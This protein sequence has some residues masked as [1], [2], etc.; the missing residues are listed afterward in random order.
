MEKDKNTNKKYK[1]LTLAQKKELCEKKRDQK[2]NNAQLAAHYKISIST[3]YDITKKSEHWLSIDINP[4]NIN[5]FREKSSNYPQLEEVMIIWVDQQISRNLTI[6]G[7]IIQQKAKECANLLDINNF[8]ASAGWLANF[9]SRNNLHAFKISGEAGSAPID[10]LPQM[11][12]ELQEVLQGY[13]LKDIW[14][15]DETALFW[16]LEPCKTIAH[17][18]VLG[19]KR[20]KER[21]SI[22][23]TC[24]ASGDE[25]LPLVYIHKYETPRA[26]IGI[27]KRSLPVWYYWNSKAWMQRSIFKHYLERLNSKMVRENRHIILLMDNA[28]CHKSDN[29][30]N[31]SNVK[32]HFLPPNTTSYLQPLDQGIIYSLKAQYCKLLCQNR[33]QIYDL[34]E[35]GDSIP[36]P[37]N[38]FDSINLIANAWKNVTKKTILNS[39][40]KTE[41]LPDNM[42]DSEY[43]SDSSDTIDE[44]NIDEELQLLINELAL[45]EPLNV[46]EYINIDDKLSTEE[47]LS[48]Q[49]IVNVIQGQNEKEIE[50]EDEVNEIITTTDALNSI[51]KIINY[52]QQK[53]LGVNSLEMKNLI[54]LKKQIIYHNINEKKQSHLNEF[55]DFNV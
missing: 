51:E 19:K 28:R 4:T 12:V 13:E 31:L 55:F 46:N 27:E 15:Y 48:L 5:N 38:I 6:S 32:I 14:N 22:L 52:I 42:R 49:E 53:N 34:Y 44:E 10:E 36:P 7:P 23:V 2:L 35:E 50:E 21:V 20:S 37:V 45:T 39:W 25:K 29:I 9:K 33:I 26:L 54:K 16:R 18:P 11:K 41:I 47:E 3:V 40:A 43:F 30:N 8:S 24:N 17:T 1:S